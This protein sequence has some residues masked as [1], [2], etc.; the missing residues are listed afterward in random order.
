M[1][2]WTNALVQIIYEKNKKYRFL[3]WIL[4]GPLKYSQLESSWTAGSRSFEVE[5]LYQSFQLSRQ[6]DRF[7]ASKLKENG[8]DLSGRLLQRLIFRPNEYAGFTSQVLSKSRYRELRL[9]LQ[10]ARKRYH[11]QE[12]KESSPMT[13]HS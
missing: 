12:R 7:T 11:C 10:K 5:Q 2:I 1:Y 8:D 9:E 6:I 13:R 3:K 4:G